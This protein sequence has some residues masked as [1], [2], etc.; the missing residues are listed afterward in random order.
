MATLEHRTDSKGNSTWRV[1]IRLK[2]HPSVS[3]TFQRNTDANN[4]IQQ[5]NYFPHVSALLNEDR[6]IPAID[7]VNT[8]G[9]YIFGLP[10]GLKINASMNALKTHDGPYTWDFEPGQQRRRKFALPKKGMLDDFGLLNKIKDLKW[11]KG[12]LDDPFTMM[13]NGYGRLKEN[14][15]S[16]KDKGT[17]KVIDGI[18]KVKGSVAKLKEDAIKLR[19]SSP[20][21]IIQGSVDRI[22][23]G[24]DNVKIGVGNLKDGSVGRLRGGVD[25]IKG[26]LDAAGDTRVGGIVKGGVDRVR[27]GLEIIGDGVRDL[28]GSAPGR[29]VTGGTDKVRDGLGRI[30]DTR[31]GGGSRD[32]HPGGY[33]PL[34]GLLRGRQIRGA[35]A[36]RQCGAH[37][38]EHS[39][40]L[41]KDRPVLPRS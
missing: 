26:G 29:L 10:K 23:G 9:G 15:V 40:S 17:G 20:R 7:Y 13:L 31:V 8:G 38:Q 21:Q 19:H 18:G 27:G 33:C 28:G 5:S 36:A 34:C 16:F 6:H 11:F 22:Q 37:P 35:Q 2:G 41:S 1:K 32:V 25:R 39:H 12:K 3:K 4:W 14:A 24:V 30:G